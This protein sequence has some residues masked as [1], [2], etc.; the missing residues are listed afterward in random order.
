MATATREASKNSMMRHGRERIHLE[1][2]NDTHLSTHYR[3][4]IPER[5][6]RRVIELIAVKPLNS[7]QSAELSICA[8]SYQNNDGTAAYSFYSNRQV[9]L[10]LE[11]KDLKEAVEDWVNEYFNLP[12]W[13]LRAWRAVTA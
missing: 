3:A 7:K 12:V 11:G 4:V 9:R 8:V 13:L 1:A 5:G 6:G 2:V 10:D